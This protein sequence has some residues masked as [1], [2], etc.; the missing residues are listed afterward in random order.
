MEHY[1]DDGDSAPAMRFL[2]RGLSPHLA[3]PFDIGLLVRHGSIAGY[4]MLKDD[5]W[6]SRARAVKIW[7]RGLIPRRDAYLR[8]SLLLTFQ[9][10]VLIFFKP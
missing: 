8:W 7:L 4:A 6:A 3:A 9:S 10:I 5:A 1:Q 2:I